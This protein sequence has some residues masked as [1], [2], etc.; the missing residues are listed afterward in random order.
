MK[1]ILAVSFIA[2]PFFLFAQENEKKVKS[3]I[4][5]VTVFLSG[6]SVTSAGSTSID[7]G[8]QD[9]VFENL[10]PFIDG[11]SIEAKGE[12]A[13]TILAVSFRTNYLNT[14]PKSKEIKQFEDSLEALQLK[15]QVQENM[16]NVYENEE[17]MLLANK[18][19][20]GQ[21]T[22]V[23]AAEL[24][25][26]ANILRMRL[27]DLNT[28]EM[29]CSLK[30]K[31]IGEEINKIQSQLNEIN[32]K[33]NKNTGEVVVSISSQAVMN[34]KLTITYNVYNAGWTPIY[35]LRAKDSNSPVQ[36]EYRANVWQSTGVDWKNVKLNISTG[37]PSV[38]GTKP[39]VNP[40][41]LSFYSPYN[42]KNKEYSKKA[43]DDKA[44]YFAAPAAA[45]GL[46]STKDSQKVEEANYSY[47]YVT[48]SENAVTVEYEISI[49]YN[50]PADS[51]P[52]SVSI[53]SLNIPASYRYYCAPKFDPDAFLLAKITGWD[54]YNLLSGN[55]NIFFEGTFVGKSYLDTKTTSDTL[56]ISLGRDKNV[57]V[58][59]TMLKDFCDK[60]I[61]GLN[62]KETRTYEIG[63][64]NKKKSEIEIEIADQ[65]P[66]ATSNEIEVEALETGGAK[67]D[68]EKGLLSWNI[69]AATGEEKKFRFSFSVKYPKDKVLSNL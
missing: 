55:L 9:L 60:K 14:Q 43:F 44:G 21:N 19:I 66:L 40:W 61:I 54:K 48:A 13:F 10:S 31:K 65:L 51:K 24:E 20:G 56:D 29:E 11:S 69:K 58:M 41:W 42:Y 17:S 4:K 39:A 32:A 6:A 68:K 57:V 37:N 62:K 22:G 25:K 8:P 30:E 53:Q 26:I 38:N 67:Y 2:I 15:I 50:I 33:R 36:L 18:N 47:N 16:H 27:T 46:I 34:A 52:H 3:E 12:G 45:D 63:I 64:R 49:P 23:N 7:A 59:R 35:D 1:S 5:N 28:K